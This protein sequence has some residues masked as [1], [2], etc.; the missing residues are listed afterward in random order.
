MEEK[1]N[2]LPTLLT[3]PMLLFIMPTIFLVVG[4]PAVLRSFEIFFK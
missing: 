3:L 1:A 4:G 2:R